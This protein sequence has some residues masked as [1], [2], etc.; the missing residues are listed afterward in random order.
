[1]PRIRHLKRELTYEELFPDSGQE[2]RDESDVDE[3]VQTGHSNADA[4]KQPQGWWSNENVIASL[5]DAKLREAYHRYKLLA[6]S[7]L[8]E[9]THRHAASVGTRGGEVGDLRVGSRRF[10]RLQHVVPTKASRKTGLKLSPEQMLQALTLLTKLK[11][12]RKH[13]VSLNTTSGV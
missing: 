4:L 2:S 12:A 6:D 1:M 10:K 7:C 9:I 8:R 13:G 11:E 3:V 5:P